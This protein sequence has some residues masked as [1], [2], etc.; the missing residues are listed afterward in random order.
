M[1]EQAPRFEYT[2]EQEAQMAARS[3]E[4]AAEPQTSEFYMGR[5]TSE[6]YLWLRA[7]S[8]AMQLAVMV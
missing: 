1:S 4:P 6:T 8:N 7:V 2:P 5:A 3:A